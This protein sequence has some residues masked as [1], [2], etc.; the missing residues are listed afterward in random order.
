MTGPQRRWLVLLFVLLAAFAPA[1]RQRRPAAVTVS[2]YFVRDLGASSTVEA[3]PRTVTGRNT[4]EL[5][6]A[7]I[8]E[9]LAGPTE[10]ERTAGLS[11]AVPAG[12][13]LHGVRVEG[14]IVA[15][16]F[17]RTVESGGGSASMLGRFWQIVYTATQLSE[18]PRVR[19]LIEG[20][21]RESMGGEGVLIDRPIARP[22]TPPRF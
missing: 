17:D 15:A 20:Q 12:T 8:Q 13:R 3:V 14:G 16:D 7:A 21:Q 18:A 10:S 22:Q 4:T 1:C 6:A 19:I 9:L 5:L 2:V 11:T